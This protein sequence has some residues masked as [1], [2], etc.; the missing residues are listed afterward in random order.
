MLMGLG[1]CLFCI[2]GDGLPV[3]LK[4][5]TTAG[6]KQILSFFYAVTES[7][8]RSQYSYFSSEV[9]TYRKHVNLD[10]YLN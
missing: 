2:P 6:Q 10:C 1:W 5:Q 8:M 3:A 9:V 7:V 4:Y